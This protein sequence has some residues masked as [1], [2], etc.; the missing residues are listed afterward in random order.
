M[1][2]SVLCKLRQ[3]DP[4]QWA[5]IIS[6]QRVKR[7]GFSI[8][9][10]FP[11]NIRIKDYIEQQSDV[12]CPQTERIL[13]PTL[14]Q[15]YFNLNLVFSPLEFMCS[16]MLLLLSL[17]C[18]LWDCGQLLEW[19]LIILLS[20]VNWSF[21]VNRYNSLW[22]YF[23]LFEVCFS[24]PFCISSIVY[25]LRTVCLCRCV[26]RPRKACPQNI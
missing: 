7:P 26:K 10:T 3:D 16:W 12:P 22:F 18:P 24:C 23:F 4:K 8:F 15:K 11:M 21:Q 19:K 20:L 17:T 14:Q 25:V 13:L 6:E 1:L 9:L 2:W 5:R